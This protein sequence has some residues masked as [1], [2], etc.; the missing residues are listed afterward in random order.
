MDKLLQ[1]LIDAA[2]AIWSQYN[3]EGPGSVQESR[4]FRFSEASCA[5]AEMLSQDEVLKNIRAGW[6]EEYHAI[7]TELDELL[8]RC[9][10][11]SEG[12]NFVTGEA[13][14]VPRQDLIHRCE[15][16]LSSLRNLAE[17]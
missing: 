3:A 11:R 13:G 14:L 8:R 15:A 9:V 16:N 1:E 5:V 17:H 6:A 4:F 10:F 2:D 7:I 12:L